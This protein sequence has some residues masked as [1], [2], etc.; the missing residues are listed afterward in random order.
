M[1]LSITINSIRILIIVIA[2]LFSEDVQNTLDSLI[3]A[4][5]FFIGLIPMRGHYDL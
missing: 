1:L 3:A 4:T 5:P 2:G